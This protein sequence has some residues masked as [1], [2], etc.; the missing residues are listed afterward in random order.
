MQ[1]RRLLRVTDGATTVHADLGRVGGDF[2][3]DMV[4]DG[5]GNA[6]VGTRTRD[7]RPSRS[8]LASS[9]ELDSLVFVDPDGHVRV[10]ADHLVAPN[11]TVIAPDGSFLVVAETYAHRLTRFDRGPDGSL[12]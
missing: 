3:N 11:G 8:P 7:M 6:Y 10:A 12:R 9:Y 4:I 2:L 5:D 1:T